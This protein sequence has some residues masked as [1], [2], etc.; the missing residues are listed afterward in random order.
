MVHKSPP[1]QLKTARFFWCLPPLFSGR[2]TLT[3]SITSGRRVIGHVYA[4][5]CRAAVH[6]SVVDDIRETIGPAAAPARTWRIGETARPRVIN[7]RAGRRLRDDRERYVVV[8]VVGTD[9]SAGNRR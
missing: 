6:L 7:N 3:F 2:L 1:E 4:H 9:H 5:R 8:V